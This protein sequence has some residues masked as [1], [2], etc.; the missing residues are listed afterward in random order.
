MANVTKSI[1]NLTHETK[2]LETS[3]LQLFEIINE[4]EP[5]I[6]QFSFSNGSVLFRELFSCGNINEAFVNA[7][8]TPILHHMNAVHGY[9]IMLIHLCRNASNGMRSILLKQWGDKELIGLKLLEN[10]V[11]LYISLVW[12]STILLGMCSEDSL[13]KTTTL[14]HNWNSIITFSSESSNSMETATTAKSHHH[15]HHHH[16]H[17]HHHP[18][19][20]A[21]A[22]TTLKSTPIDGTTNTSHPESDAEC[23]QNL[24]TNK[25]KLQ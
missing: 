14:S 21:Q 20:S 3:L 2:V 1:F 9:V 17:H 16:H 4:L 13:I 10:L 8:L 22:Q 23:C 19:S 7:E 15:Y 24:L 18:P 25:V 12:E 5:L 11:K 6:E